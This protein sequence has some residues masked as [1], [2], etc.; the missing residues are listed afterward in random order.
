MPDF[1]VISIHVPKASGSSISLGLSNH[2]GEGFTTLYNLDPVDPCSAEYIDPIR[3][4]AA[5][6]ASIEPFKAIHGH[7]SPRH[8]DRIEKARRIAMLREPVDNLISIYFFWRKYFEAGNKGHA[9]YEYA[10]SQNLTLL[11]FA[12]LPNLR[13]LYSRSYFGNFDMSK[14]DVIGSYDSRV[15]YFEKVSELCGCRIDGSIHANKTPTSEERQLLSADSK[16]MLS[17]RT[18]LSDDI[19]FFEAHTSP[20]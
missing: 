14:F 16:L 1:P 11:E 8:F 13:F 20:A 5:K 12:Q 2:F 19:R 10:M 9:L 15:E 6:P 3:Y 17:L 7:F 18:L 4:N